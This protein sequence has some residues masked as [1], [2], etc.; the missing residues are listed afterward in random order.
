MTNQHLKLK[1]RRQAGWW[2]YLVRVDELGE[3]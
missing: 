1:M 2:V 3:V